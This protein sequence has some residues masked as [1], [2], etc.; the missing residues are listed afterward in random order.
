MQVRLSDQGEE[1]CVRPRN[2]SHTSPRKSR[3]K[4]YGRGIV[5]H[6]NFFC[7]SIG[8]S[9][10]KDVRLPKVAIYLALQARV[11]VMVSKYSQRI[12]REK[13]S[14]R[15]PSLAKAYFRLNITITVPPLPRLPSRELG[16]PRNGWWMCPTYNWKD[17]L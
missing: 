16:Y 6:S 2:S 11:C 9:Y 7:F 4:L 8:V 17:F 12:P 3:S 5:R 13:L 14:L 10:Q 1:V 15:T